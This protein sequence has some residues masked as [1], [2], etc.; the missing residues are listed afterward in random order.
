MRRQ[1][2]GT[3]HFCNLVIIVF[4]AARSRNVTSAGERNSQRRVIDSAPKR[5]IC[6]SHP[7]TANLTYK[8]LGPQPSVDVSQS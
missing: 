2:P 6:L 4:L 1:S 5:M 8:L 3:R 7:S